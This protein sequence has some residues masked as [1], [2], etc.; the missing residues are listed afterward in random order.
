MK[1]NKIKTIVIS[2]TML[3]ASLTTILT[4]SFAKSVSKNDDP[5]QLKNED[6]SDHYQGRTLQAV[7]SGTS[8]SDET[9][10][11]SVRLGD[12]PGMRFKYELSADM[13]NNAF[14][15]AAEDLSSYSY[16]V[17][18]VKSENL[19]PYDLKELLQ[20]NSD[21]VKNA[22]TSGTLQYEVEL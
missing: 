16:G 14:T 22:T 18:V 6:L 19:N 12:A 1:S 9:A 21:L 4:L 2:S 3:L 8:L 11:V 20:D 7:N 13:I 15:T 5:L 17:V 10:L